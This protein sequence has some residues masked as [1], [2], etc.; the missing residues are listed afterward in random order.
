VSVAVNVVWFKRDLRVTDH[1]PLVAAC[2][3]GPVLPLYVYEPSL[4]AQPDVS[5]QHV[6]FIN[7]CLQTLEAELNEIG[8]KLV[9]RVGEIID[10]LTVIKLSAGNF[11]LWSHEETGNGATYE[12]DKQVAAWCRANGVAWH[13]SPSGAVVRRLKDRDRWSALW[14]QRMKNAPLA[15]PSR[16]TTAH[17]PFAT[18]GIVEI[19]RLPVNGADKPLRQRGGRDVALADLGSFFNERGQFYRSEMSSPLSAAD[20]CS[21]ISAHLAYGTLSIREAVH[22]VWQQRAKLLAMD[23]KTREPGWL[24]SLKSF[25]GRLHWHCHF[26]QKLERD[27]SIEFTNMHRAYAGVR[28]DN[29]NALLQTAWRNGETGMPMIDACMRMLAAT[30]W[31]NFRMRAMLVSFSSY[32]LWQHWREPALHLAREF[33]DYEPGIH[34]P[35]VQMQSGTT[36][37]NTVRMYN[38]VK[39]ARDQDPTGEFVRRWI[40][41]LAR[42]PADFIFEPWRMP[43]NLQREYRCVIGHNYPAPVVDLA[44]AAKRARDAIWI[45]RKEPDFRKEAQAIFETHGSRNPVREG[46]R[47]ARRTR[48]PSQTA[49][50]ADA[51]MTLF[52]TSDH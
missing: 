25:E 45:K 18:R 2:A 39:Q 10:V 46:V 8:L 1:A 34:Y 33:L 47:G 9:T 14:M 41:A 52:D 13:E 15:K 16:A 36:G 31:I 29:H 23:A 32:H 38:P 19:N 42:V 51:Q 3:H 43:E 6:A 28:E 30:G 22:A 17:R 49:T 4:I 40:P 24:A 26:I 7:E 21:R 27:P 20:A 12:R 5:A 37:I 35:Q 48:L 44:S 11:T 50:T